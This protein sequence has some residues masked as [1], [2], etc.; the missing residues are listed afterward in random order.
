MEAT[1]TRTYKFNDEQIK[2][3]MMDNGYVDE[4]DETKP[5]YTSDDVETELELAS[6]DD[7]EFYG[8]YDMIWGQDLEVREE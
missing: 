7:L 8:N 5:D 4:E 1:I 2:K 3:F 6:A